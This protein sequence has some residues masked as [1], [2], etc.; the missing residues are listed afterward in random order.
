MKADT[1]FGTVR[2]SIALL[3]STLLLY[4]CMKLDGYSKRDNSGHSGGASGESAQ[5]GDSGHGDTAGGASTIGDSEISTRASNIG[6][7][8]NTGGLLGV[9]DSMPIAPTSGQ[10][11]SGLTAKCQQNES[12]CTGYSVPGG[13][14]MMGRG[15]TITDG[16]YYPEGHSDEVPAHSVSVRS[17]RLDKFE[18]TVGRYRRFVD[19]YAAGWRP[20]VGETGAHAQIPESGWL[21]GWDD[22]SNYGT[23]LPPTG[24][25]FASTKAMFATRLKCDATYQ[26]WTDVA[27]SNESFPIN[28][29]NWYEAMAFCIWDGGYLPTEAEWEYAAAGGNEER[30]YPWGSLPTPNRSLATYGDLESGAATPFLAVGS[31]TDGHGRWLHEDLAGSLWE[32]NLDARADDWYSNEKAS[33]ADVCYLAAPTIRISRGGSW[34]HLANLLRV[35]YRGGSEPTY[36]SSRLGLRCAGAK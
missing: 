34:Y 9:G 30:L 1:D 11:C 2:S 20:V 17:Y 7:T 13:T 27:G 4:A 15:I 24:S 33:G 8:S 26:T 31:K 14:F 6:G 18:V 22:S 3:I 32:W 5:G 10:S 16:D 35:T 23:K 12:C 36:R 21:D 29:V 25:D 19:A 28:C